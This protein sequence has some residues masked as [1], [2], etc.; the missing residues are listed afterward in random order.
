MDGRQGGDIQ[1]SYSMLGLIPCVGKCVA[2]KD[3][4]R[5]GRSILV[6]TY[7]STTLGNS[8]ALFGDAP[9]SSR[10]SLAPKA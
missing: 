8:H 4:G 10:V 9:H 7:S 1:D 6:A 2:L 3:A 5:T